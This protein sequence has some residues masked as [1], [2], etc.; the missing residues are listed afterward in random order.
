MLLK[1]IKQYLKQGLCDSLVNKLMNDVWIDNSR[2]AWPTYIFDAISKFLG[3]FTTRRIY[4][5]S[6][7]C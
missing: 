6:K 5:F 2:T 4:H 1:K 3:Q 7:R